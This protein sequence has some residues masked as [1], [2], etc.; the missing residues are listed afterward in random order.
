MYVSIRD[1]PGGITIFHNT[2]F[3]KICIFKM[4]I[5]LAHLQSCISYSHL[6]LLVNLV[7]V[8]LIANNTFYMYLTPNSTLF[9]LICFFHCY[10]L[11]VRLSIL[12]C[13]VIYQH[14][15]REWSRIWKGLKSIIGEKEQRTKDYGEKYVKRY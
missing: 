11:R 6:S 13:Y 12:H 14:R 4:L 5:C 2:L 8:I 10:V 15:C 3:Q 7:S 1:K 9:F